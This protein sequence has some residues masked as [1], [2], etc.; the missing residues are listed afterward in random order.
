MVASVQKIRT[1]GTVQLGLPYGIANASGQLS[2]SEAVEILRF[3]YEHG[4]RSFDTARAYGDSEA[5]ISEFIAKHRPAEI[6]IATKLKPSQTPLEL[7]ESFEK[8]LDALGVES[9]DVL[10]F[11]RWANRVHASALEPFRDRFGRLGVSVLDKDE[12]VEAIRDSEIRFI[13]IPCNLL[14][15]RWRD[16]EWARLCVV[17]PDVE[18]QCRSILLQG[19]L[20]DGADPPALAEKFPLAR[21]LGRVD[22]LAKKFGMPGR[23]ALAFAYVNSLSWIQNIV[24][25]VDRQDQLQYNLSLLDGN[26]LLSPEAMTEVAA[27]F[28]EESVPETLLQPHLWGI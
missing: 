2:R 26:A 15:W 20:S 7:I 25:G 12:A 21:L 10:M 18:I 14:D 23:T 1:L 6:Q 28:S 8:S 22:G 5:V 3:A 24:F 17:R 4:V 11:H 16:P 27:A 13:Q 19:V 9:V